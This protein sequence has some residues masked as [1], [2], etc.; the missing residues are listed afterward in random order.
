MPCALAAAAPLALPDPSAT[1]RTLVISYPPDLDIESEKLWH[2]LISIVHEHEFQLL[3]GFEEMY[4]APDT[5]II[6]DSVNIEWVSHTD[7]KEVI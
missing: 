4:R 5:C 3:I 6:I 1:P 7:L 2:T